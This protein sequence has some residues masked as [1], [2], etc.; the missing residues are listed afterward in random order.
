MMPC[1]LSK[2][3]T[4]Y[5]IPILLALALAGCDLSQLNNPYPTDQDGQAILYQSF[6]ERPKHLD[7][8]I[9]YS[10]NEYA[11]IAQIY[12]PP[13][14]Y[15]YLKRPF[16]LIPLTASQMPQVQYLNKQ[17]EKLDPNSDSKDIAF[18]DYQ[19]DIKPGIRYQPHPAFAKTVDG[20]YEY[21]QLNQNQM[22]TLSTLA[23]FSHTG[24]RDLVAEDFV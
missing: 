16:E 12:E 9:A 3:F 24:T 5:Q 8:A 2:Y 13:F 15:H 1:L 21:H 22:A 10:E 20:Q 7:P 14:Q 18:T 19:I 17:G 4:L 11:F 6:D 23:D